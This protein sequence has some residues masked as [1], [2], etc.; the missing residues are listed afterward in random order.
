MFLGYKRYPFRCVANFRDLGGYPA[1]GRAVTRY[2]VFFRCA[3][4]GDA[5]AEDIQLLRRLGVR[6]ILDLRYPEDLAR[7]PDA[8]SRLPDFETLNIS[9]MGDVSPA[10]IDVNAGEED[11]LTLRGMYR[12]MLEHG[13]S[14]LVSA[15]RALVEAPGGAAFHCFNG[16]DRTGM[17]A[18]FLLSAAGV[19]NCDI[20]ADYEVSHTYIEHCTDD[21][22]G[23]H[24]KN[25]KWTLQYLQEQYGSPTGY[26]LANGLSPETLA[27]LRSRLVMPLPPL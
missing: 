8:T 27:A 14:A 24:Y 11:T 15:V 25:M 3:H 10:Q 21:I 23:S 20:V 22:S 19:A 13:G 4:L 18:M 12:Q 6:R 17:L 9:L 5:C 1:G 7:V 16:K 26:L 2:G